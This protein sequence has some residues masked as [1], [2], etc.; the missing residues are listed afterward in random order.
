[1][2]GGGGGGGYNGYLNFITLIVL[3]CWLLGFP[4]LFLVLLCLHLVLVLALEC[5]NS[6]VQ[7]LTVLGAVCN[8]FTT[9]GNQR[10]ERFRKSVQDLCQANLKLIKIL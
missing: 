3:L 9:L 2:G 6:P 4:L 5:M 7:Q 1:M 10:L 8:S